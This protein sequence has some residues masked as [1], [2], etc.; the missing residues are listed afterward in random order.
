MKTINYILAALIVGMIILQSCSFLF[1]PEK[2]PV[3]ATDLVC[4]MKV[5]K[6]DAYVWRYNGNKYYFDNYN[7]KQTFKMNPEKFLN[8]KCVSTRDSIPAK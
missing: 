7:C 3:Y 1:Y 2:S 5:N 8:N 4:G 6:A